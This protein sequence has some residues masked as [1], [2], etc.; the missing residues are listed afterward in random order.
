MGNRD[1]LKS[2]SFC[3][4]I[5]M[6]SVERNRRWRAQNPEL[7]RAAN[8][9]YYKA[10]AEKIKA[11][12]RR[13]Y[14]ENPDVVLDRATK[15]HKENPRKSHNSKLK[16]AFGITVD[17]YEAMLAAQGGTCAACKLPLGK[18]RLA[19]D[20]CHESGAVRGLLCGACNTAL[21]LLR[22]CP[23]R[24]QALKDYIGRHNWLSTT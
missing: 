20:H 10:N 1:L 9:R 23:K 5:A 15:W 11:R 2:V 19:V 16:Y 8:K 24:M 6:N 3:I 17:Q 22:E 14:E 12:A 21:G 4:C 7:Y 18:R 13:W